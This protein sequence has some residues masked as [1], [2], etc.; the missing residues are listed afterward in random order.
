MLK[1]RGLTTI[2]IGFGRYKCKIEDGFYV[3]GRFQNVIRVGELEP[4]A[5]M[6]GLFKLAKSA[7]RILLNM[8][9]D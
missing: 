8:S 2:R 1:K 5:S 3:I 4:L 7:S 6:S 9:H